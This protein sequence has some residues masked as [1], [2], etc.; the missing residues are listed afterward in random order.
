MSLKFSLH[1]VRHNSWKTMCLLNQTSWSRVICSSVAGVKR[2]Q[3]SHNANCNTATFSC[4][5]DAKISI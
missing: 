1:L 2:N 3:L 5:S 4:V